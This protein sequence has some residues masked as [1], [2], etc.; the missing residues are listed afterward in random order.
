MGRGTW[1]RPFSELN[2]KAGVP[3]N[4]ARRAGGTRLLRFLAILLVAMWAAAIAWGLA[5]AADGDAQ[6][7]G[8]LIRGHLD[9]QSSADPRI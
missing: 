2:G 9:P 4:R 7:Q 8:P 5:M 3:E 1:A 6:V